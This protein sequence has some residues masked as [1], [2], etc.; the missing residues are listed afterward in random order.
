MDFGCIEY[1]F[2]G[3]YVAYIY[4]YIILIKMTRSGNSTFF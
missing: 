4:I 1:C 2:I 3:N